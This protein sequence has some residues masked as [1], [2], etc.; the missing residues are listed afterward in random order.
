MSASP[1][2]ADSSRPLAISWAKITVRSI[3]ASRW[4]GMAKASASRACGIAMVLARASLG[5]GLRVGKSVLGVV[6][7]AFSMVLPFG[8]GWIAG[9]L[10]LY[11]ILL[12]Q[13][14]NPGFIYR[15]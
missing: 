11:K 1:S 14:K 13:G 12:G 15:R 4:A 6:L 9:A 8:K 3:R 2:S 10:G 5:R 7:S